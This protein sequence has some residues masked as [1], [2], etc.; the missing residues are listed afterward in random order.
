MGGTEPIWKGLACS[1]TM[2]LSAFE[3]HRSWK[4][5]R[6]YNSTADSKGSKKK[7]PKSDDAADVA[8]TAE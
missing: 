2:V 1:L 3:V 5:L 4:Q 6:Q 8:E 7:K